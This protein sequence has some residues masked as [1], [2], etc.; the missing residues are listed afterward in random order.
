[1]SETLKKM[2][3]CTLY[4]HYEG[5][6]PLAVKSVTRCVNTTDRTNNVDACTCLCNISYFPN[7]CVCVCVRC[8]SET[9]PAFPAGFP[10]SAAKRQLGRDGCAVSAKDS[11]NP[12]QSALALFTLWK[13]IVFEIMCVCVQLWWNHET[14]VHSLRAAL[15]QNHPKNHS[16]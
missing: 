2:A 7:L 11:A 5:K 9:S 8:P 12:H 16:L 4:L 15:H 13:L 1:M 10:A 3:Q 6:L 14:K